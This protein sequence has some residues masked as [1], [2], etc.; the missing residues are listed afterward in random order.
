MCICYETILFDGKS[1][2]YVHMNVHTYIHTYICLYTGFTLLKYVIW[3]KTKYKYQLQF[4]A[5]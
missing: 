1:A 2:S 3:I 5:Y 4:P